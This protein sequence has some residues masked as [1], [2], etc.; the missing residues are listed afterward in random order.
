ME[1]SF[2][3]DHHNEL[4]QILGQRLEAVCANEDVPR[5]QLLVA[6]TGSGKSRIIRE[7][8][9]SLCHAQTDP[10]YWPELDGGDHYRLGVRSDPL[11]FRKI[12]GPST[13]GFAWE[14]GS[15]PNFFWW[16]LNCDQSQ[17]GAAVRVVNEFEREMREHV[18]ALII[19][20]RRAEGKKDS[21]TRQ[22]WSDLRE[23]TDKLLEAGMW[24]AL[25]LVLDAVGV[26]TMGLGVV[27]ESSKVGIKAQ[28]T[29]RERRSAYAEGATYRPGNDVGTLIDALRRFARPKMPVII[30]VEDLHLMGDDLTL[31][32][33]AVAEFHADRP[34]L[35]VGTAWPEGES[36]ECYRRWLHGARAEEK[37]EIHALEGLELN[38]L[39]LIVREFAPNTDSE[40]VHRVVAHWPTPLE[41]QLGLSMEVMRKRIADGSLDVNDKILDKMP[42]ALMSLYGARLLELPESVRRALLLAAASLPEKGVTSSSFLRG[43]VARAAEGIDLIRIGP[44][45]PGDVVN[46]LVRANKPLCWTINVAGDAD[47][48]REPSLLEVLSRMLDEH[49]SDEIDLF[50]ERVL[51]EL[52][53]HLSD[54]AD[55]EEDAEDDYEERLEAC[56][57]YYVLAGATQRPPDLAFVSAV[58]VLADH[59]YKAYGYREVIAL[60]EPILP[61]AHAH[62]TAEVLLSSWNRLAMAYQSIG[63][64]DKAIRLFAK[65]LSESREVLGPDHRLV[66]I[67]ALNLAFAYKS[68]GR[69][70]EAVA[71]NEQIVVGFEHSLEANHPD[72]E[73]AR[74]NLALAYESV[75]R[76]DEAI[77][78]L[79]QNLAVSAERSGGDSPDLLRAWSNL[80][81]AYGTIGRFGEAIT[82]F[83]RAVA[84]C[85]P[86]IGADHPDLLTVLNNLAEVYE[87]LGRT[88][89]AV[90]LL[91]RVVAGRERSVGEDDPST[92]QA[93]RNLAGAYQSS[94]RLD[95]AAAMLA[96]NLEG[97]TG[98][99]G[100]DHPD[101]LLTRNNLGV[102]YGSMGLMEEALEILQE[103]AVDAC[104]LLGPDNPQSLGFQQ[105]VGWAYEKL[106]RL[107]EAIEIYQR[108]VDDYER[109]LGPHHPK[110][111]S[112]RNALA[113]AYLSAGLSEDALILLEQFV[114]KHE[115]VLGADHP[116]TLGSRSDLAGA[117]QTIGR[118][119]E[120]ITLNELTLYD[121]ERVLGEDHPHT[122]VSR[123]NLAD[124]YKWPVEPRMR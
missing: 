84:V 99:L 119:E 63:Q 77:P 55:P 48:F 78:L 80:A 35:L 106:G 123:S 79:E 33:D 100:V 36:N 22:L 13:E 5:I 51:A 41:L 19:G 120:A 96:S 61:D 31:F 8:Y 65:T 89:E 82:L 110:T 6:P 11:P 53:S 15:V 81:E 87:S 117:L 32:L 62:M 108:T 69:T 90:A 70:S 86:A 73:T 109:V 103:T 30:V 60:L 37:V 58:M 105:N 45:G 74:N 85:E 4:M 112:S 17:S 114:T 66:S 95:T 56:R 7:F 83:E 49:D 111:L 121:R 3:G 12:L 102:T 68:T 23:G 29:L 43:I 40:T 26:P 16:A 52:S 57:W 98:V 116:D 46:D 18:P 67:L 75:G 113:N 14:P 24:D 101:T 20:M 97:M 76:I 39:G 34:I 122:R 1:P 54:L 47:R 118:V 38:E 42:Q 94:G 107:D 50:R 72:L 28:R 64:T 10:V 124:T 44:H 91:E 2:V 27:V 25:T 92:F 9:R 88:D 93:R 71:L 104:R 115:Q 21:F 59:A